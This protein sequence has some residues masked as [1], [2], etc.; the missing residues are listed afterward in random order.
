M[1]DVVA[2]GLALGFRSARLAT[3]TSA[4]GLEGNRDDL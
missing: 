2:L 4:N 3:P 1:M